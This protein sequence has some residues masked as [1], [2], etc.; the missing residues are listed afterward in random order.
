M[1]NEQLIL[2]CLTSNDAYI[3]SVIPFLK[4]E[5]FTDKAEQALFLIS[6]SYFKKYNACASSEVLQI[7]IEKIKGM[8]DGIYKKAIDIIKLLEKETVTSTNEWLIDTTEAFVKEKALQLAL[9]KSIEIYQG[10]DKNLTTTSIPHL[11]TE[12]LSVGFDTKLGHD[13]INDYEHQLDYYHSDVMRIPT[14]VDILNDITNGGFPRKTLNMVIMKTHGGKSLTLCSLASGFYM[15]GANVLY[16]TLEESEEEIR[17][18]ID[19]NI[20]DVGMD[21]LLK[22]SKTLYRKKM[23]WVES[24]TKGKLKV[25]YFTNG[26]AGVSHFRY[27]LEEYKNKENFVPDVILID[28]LNLCASDRMKSKEQIAYYIKS[29]AEELRGFAAET[30]TALFS[31]LQFNRG[32][33]KEDSNAEMEDVAD[34]FAATFVGDFVA[35]LSAPD[36]LRSKN[37]ML[38]KQAKNRHRNLNYK[39]KFITG[40]DP[41]KMRV[42]DIEQSVQP[43]DDIDSLSQT[44]NN[45]IRKEDKYDVIDKN[46]GEVLEENVSKAGRFAAFNFNDEEDE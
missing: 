44:K 43:I 42:Y 31:A 26:S 4:K 12:A 27:L 34:S 17:K 39:K 28:Y 29:V 10:N 6:S 33:S 24:K 3:R 9:Q 13:Y 45:H 7:E 14:D 1:D 20:L 16:I 36:E 30:N 40:T 37:M 8:P 19:A 25:K 15:Q 11:L 41:Q 38:W 22:I 2:K 5:Y 23:A 35:L 46:T 32:G 18:R 21:A